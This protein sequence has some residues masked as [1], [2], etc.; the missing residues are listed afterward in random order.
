MTD[1]VSVRQYRETERLQL[2]DAALAELLG[3]HKNH[4]D[5]VPT[6]EGGHVIRGGRHVGVVRLPDL[7]VVITPKIPP[8]SV[9]WMLGYASRI[10][11][12]KGDW[13]E[14]SSETGVLEVLARVFSSQVQALVRRG[15]YQEY[16][17]RDEVLPFVRGRILIAETIRNGRGLVHKPT[18]R[19][20][21]LTADTHVNQALRE[22]TEVLARFSYRAESI[23]H[24]LDWNLRALAEAGVLPA[25]TM[26][27]PAHQLNRLNEH[28]GPALA[29]ARLILRHSTFRLEAGAV[30][31]PTFL[32]N[33][34]VV[35]QEYLSVLLAQEAAEF[36]LH[37]TATGP[38]FLDE[39]K[40]VR[41]KPDIIL[42]RAKTPALAIDAKYKRESP[43]GDV[44][45]ALAY[46]KALDLPRV[47]LVYPDDGEVKPTT[48][49]IRHDAVEVLIRTIPVGASRGFADLDERASQAARHLIE[50]LLPSASV[51]AAA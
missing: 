15:L 49:R 45:Q 17:E 25:R 1:T 10:A 50:E 39:G 46:A 12:P 31:S 14:L 3:S 35:F 23:N 6:V 26:A 51:H 37:A 21:E 8:L 16:I 4:V 30:R 29:V 18:C 28:Y 34:D 11:V 2:S 40:S 32:V 5:T 20:A 13:T 43:E 47:S 48:L 9:F 27:R 41:I 38:L 24:Q 7:D 42:S 44:Y 22:A 33:M 19:H 36:G